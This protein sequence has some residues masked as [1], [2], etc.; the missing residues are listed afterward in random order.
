MAEDLNIGVQKPKVVYKGLP[1]Y[2]DNGCYYMA[3]TTIKGESVDVW[4]TLFK[5]AKL[6][7]LVYGPVIQ[8]VKSNHEVLL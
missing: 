4:D 2:S 1:N 8:A 6:L 3:I 7:G 5:Q